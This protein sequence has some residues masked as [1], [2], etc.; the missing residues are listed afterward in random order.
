[1]RLF[2]DPVSSVFSY[3][4]LTAFVLHFI[5]VSLFFFRPSR[6]QFV[7]LYKRVTEL[8][9]EGQDVDVT[10]EPSKKFAWNK[11]QDTASALSR[12]IPTTL[13]TIGILGT[14]YGIYIG[15]SEF[16]PK[17]VGNS[18]SALLEG[19][20]I[21]FGT[22]ILGIMTGIL[23]KVSTTFLTYEET[24]GGA[25]AD[26]IITAIKNGFREQTE[27]L[28]TFADK[29]EKNSTE[30]LIKSLQKVMDDFNAK[31]N[32]QLGENFKKLNES[33]GKLVDWQENHEGQMDSMQQELR[34][35]IA[36]VKEA[37][38]ALDSSA[39]SLKSVEE[40]TKAI[41]ENVEH[42][43]K[44]LQMVRGDLEAFAEMK[45]KAI[46]VMPM[47][48]ANMNA[49]TQGLTDHVQSINTQLG[50]NL[51]TL[52]NEFSDEVQAM[53]QQLNKSHEEL[54]KEVHGSVEEAIETIAENLG[55]I[56]EENSGRL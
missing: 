44:I 51:E 46:E 28:N 43:D 32:D 8:Y 53:R 40:A 54:L 49:L 1:M 3:I 9:A 17:E 31:I 25:G 20:K 36:A 56:S 38:Q 10:R 16:N 26:E 24:E 15:L 21:A 11:H 23:S 34:A 37:R 12:L 18:V 6:N 27:A 2:E 35:A 19:L 39:Q 7:E 47:L 55:R 50:H 14:F 48:E 52:S 41:P 42:L 30:A 4:I 5:V 22:S 29:M 33:V 13:T 45:D